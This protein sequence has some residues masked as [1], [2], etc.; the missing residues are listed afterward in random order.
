MRTSSGSIKPSIANV[1]REAEALAKASVIRKEGPAR[2]Q[3][4]YRAGDAK[5]AVAGRAILT[6]RVAMKVLPDQRP[7]GTGATRSR[8][9]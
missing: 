4:V 7:D 8:T 5:R 9:A 3:L 6:H 2:F 1:Q